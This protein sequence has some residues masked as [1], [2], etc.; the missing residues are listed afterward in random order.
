MLLASRAMPVGE[1]PFCE[2]P[3]P[4]GQQP[5]AVDPLA[6]P[7]LCV[8]P[9]TLYPDLTP[10]Q[11]IRWALTTRD[12]GWA[13]TTA[14][15][16][17][18]I[19]VARPVPPV[20]PVPTPDVGK[21]H[22]ERVMPLLPLLSAIPA[23]AWEPMLRGE[24][25]DLTRSR[26]AITAV[27]RAASDR[28]PLPAERL[29]A[30]HNC[31]R[32][33]GVV[34]VTP[35]LEFASGHPLQPE[36]ALTVALMARWQHHAFRALQFGDD[37]EV[38]WEW[39]EA[40]RALAASP[41]RWEVAGATGTGAMPE[42]PDLAVLAEQ[43]EVAH[44]RAVALDDLSGKTLGEVWPLLWEGAAAMPRLDPALAERLVF[45]RGTAPEPRASIVG[46]VLTSAWCVCDTEKRPPASPAD[47][48]VWATSGAAPNEAAVEARRTW[49]EPD[50]G[51]TERTD[52]FFATARARL[53]LLALP[54]RELF[55]S[56]WSGVWAEIPP[57]AREA[58]C[59]SLA[60]VLRA[61]TQVMEGRADRSSPPPDCRLRARYRYD[62]VLGCCSP[63]PGDA[64]EQ[65][66]AAYYDRLGADRARPMYRGEPVQVAGF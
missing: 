35:T 32:L 57:E 38:S 63:W 10:E 1:D 53:P 40:S 12:P 41:C 43:A 47:W 16:M 50:P 7:F 46:A 25:T 23:E 55:A 49:Y 14:P 42:P 20:R 18:G 15:T 2:P 65:P 19:S 30:I 62:L 9:P 22:R 24:V 34:N 48:T 36:P 4:A 31:E 6:P 28:Q 29:E 66:N 44:P 39:K 37:G 54:A 59:Q 3:N 11:H 64:P 8:L 33:V 61:D 13:M 56:G 60:G 52:A 58:L 45:A 21:L 51:L 17:W 26:E 27:L 5:P